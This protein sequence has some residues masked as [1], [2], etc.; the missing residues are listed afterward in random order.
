[1]P[2]A[3]VGHIGL[4]RDPDHPDG[5][6]VLLQGAGAI[7]DDREVIAVDPMLATAHFRHRGGGTG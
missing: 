1:M 6:R 4:Y 2:A 5:D 7:W 3:R